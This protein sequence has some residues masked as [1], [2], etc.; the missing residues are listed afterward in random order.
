M[1]M[2]WL[3]N[4]IELRNLEDCVGTFL[5]VSFVSHKESTCETMENVF[6]FTSYALLVLEIMKC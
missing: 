6:D 4:Q 1:N 3:P 5:L 2:I